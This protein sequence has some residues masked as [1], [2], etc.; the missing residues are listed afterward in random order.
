M[1]RALNTLDRYAP[2]LFPLPAV[3]AVVILIAIPVLANFALS[4]FS[5]FISG[6]PS[7]IG[8]DNFQRA[9]TDYRFWNGVR[10]TFY[11]TMLAVPL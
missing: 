11:F 9:L 8:L 6:T 4:T 1:K 2:W 10:N 5:W 3:L 7:F